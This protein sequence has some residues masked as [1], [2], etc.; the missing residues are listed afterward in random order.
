MPVYSHTQLALFEQCP[1]RY[2]FT[3]IDKLRKPEEQGAE[4]FVGSRVHENL[5]KLYDDLKY[6]KLDSL[7]ELIAFYKS[8][9]RRNWRP[10]ITVNMENAA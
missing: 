2:K 3:Y 7:N 5:E 8:E 6:G 10:A 4:A 1:Q 9:W